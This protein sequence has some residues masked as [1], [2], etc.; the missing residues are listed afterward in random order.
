MCTLGKNVKSDLK[1]ISENLLQVEERGRP[2][3]LSHTYCQLKSSPQSGLFNGIKQVC[4]NVVGMW[5]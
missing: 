4:F 1:T 3:F 2:A 5:R